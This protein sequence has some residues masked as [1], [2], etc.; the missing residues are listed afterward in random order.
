[1]TV[2]EYLVETINSEYEIDKEGNI[3]SSPSSEN[4]VQARLA[5]LGDEGWELVTFL[6]A[7]PAKHFKGMPQNPWLFHAVFKRP[8]QPQE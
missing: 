5:N 2:W 7:A 6:P 3:E 1:M 4:I 8:G